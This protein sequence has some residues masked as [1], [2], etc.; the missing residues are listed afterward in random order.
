M[1]EDDKELITI[2]YDFYNYDA[3]DTKFSQRFS[4]FTQVNF[5]L[6]LYFELH[7]EWQD[8]VVVITLLSINSSFEDAIDDA[9]EKLLARMYKVGRVEQ[10]ETADQAKSRGNSSVIQRKLVQ[11]LTPSTLIHGNIG[12]QAVHLLSLKE[13]TSDPADGTTAFGFAFV[14]CA[15]LQFW[16][17]SVTDDA[18]C[19]ALGALLMQ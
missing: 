9:I 15:S 12:P 19:A 11:V 14:D 18:S 7:P 6:P 13:G 2:L 3:G 1:D 5:F 10:L 16:I 17:G 4:K 8:F